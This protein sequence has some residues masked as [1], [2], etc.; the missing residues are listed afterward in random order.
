MNTQAQSVNSNNAAEESLNKMETMFG[1]R[2]VKVVFEDNNTEEVKV[3][4]LPLRDYDR[5]FAVIDDEIALTAHICGK[6]KDWALSLQ[7]ESYEAL[8]EK[9][10]E[11]NGRGFFG[12]SERK[13]R[14]LTKFV[15]GM[16]PEIAQAAMASTSQNGSSRQPL[17]P[18]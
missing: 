8:Q 13:S 5:A 12:W 2:V 6:S 9:A 4:Q 17:R 14:E 7:P 10:R 1:G 3:R 11:V 16:G 18:R 15:A